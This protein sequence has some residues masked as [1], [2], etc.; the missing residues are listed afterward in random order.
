MQLVEQYGDHFYFNF[1]FDGVGTS[2]IVRCHIEVYN[3][4]VIFAYVLALVR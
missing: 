1:S 4:V 3:M 2:V